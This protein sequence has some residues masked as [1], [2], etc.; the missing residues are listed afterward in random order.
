[1]VVLAIL[2]RVSAQSRAFMKY[3]IGE[4]SKGLVQQHLNPIVSKRISIVEGVRFASY[5][6]LEYAAMLSDAGSLAWFWRGNH[7]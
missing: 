4:Y 6:W 1:M 3:A 2:A 5:G 7:A